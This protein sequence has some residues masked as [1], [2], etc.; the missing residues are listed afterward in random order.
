M[1]Q[2]TAVQDLTQGNV[3]K[4]LI[5]FSAPF[6]LSSL[7]QTLYST[8]DMLVVGQ[9]VGSAGLSA[10]SIA[11]NLIN[12]AITIC[13]GF[14]HAGQVLIAQATGAKQSEQVQSIA[15]TLAILICASALLIGGAA[16]VFSRQLLRL[17]HTPEEAFDLAR[18]YLLTCSAGLIFTALYNMI[19]ALFRGMGDSRHPFFFVLI[20]SVVNLVLDVLLVG[21]FRLSVFGAA[22]ATVIGQACSVAFSVVFLF[23]HSEEFHI[24]FRDWRFDG[25]IAGLLARLGLPMAISSSAV[26][27]SGLF[28]SSMVNQLGVGVSAAFGTG[29]KLGGIPH[30]VTM[31]ISMGTGAMV[32]QNIGAKKFDR[33]RKTIYSAVLITA[34]VQFAFTALSLAFPVGIF[35]LFTQD[36][37]VLAYA[38]PWI[39]AMAVA[40]PA[41]ILMTFNGIING[42]GD[43]RTSMMIGLTDAFLGRVLLSYLLGIVLHL[44]AQGFF[45]GFTCSAYLTGVPGLL[46]FLFVKWEKKELLDKLERPV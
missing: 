14:A 26:N 23:R 5:L 43:A 33:T 16:M 10:T 20:A 42:V 8:V 34:V 2:K 11:A 19:S 18:S 46:Y 40:S 36:E 9:F 17:L 45:L 39:I 15:S 29:Q 38:R 24:L 22:L 32:A 28:V 41:M 30:I 6:L 21:V 31:A 1:K 27:I 3:M 7:L 25:K 44:G 37:V 4:T 35:R 12:L 13:I